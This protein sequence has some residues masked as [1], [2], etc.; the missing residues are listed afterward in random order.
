MCEWVA[1]K[2]HRDDFN[3]VGITPPRGRQGHSVPTPKPLGEIPLSSGVSKVPSGV[4]N[5]PPFA[6]VSLFCGLKL[7]VHVVF[8]SFLD[9][10]WIPGPLQTSSS[11]AHPL[12]IVV[13]VQ[14]FPLLSFTP[15]ETMCLGGPSPSWTE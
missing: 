4:N 12:A 7:L 2:M 9:R 3:S 11:Q 6:S 15:T 10:N 8:N 14:P 13:A 5:Q 1:L